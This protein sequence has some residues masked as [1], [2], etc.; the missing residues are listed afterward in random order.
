M[1]TPTIFDA[2]EI[3]PQQIARERLLKGLAIALVVLVVIGVPLGY[4]YRN[5]FYERAVDAFFQKV[6]QKDFETAFALWTADPTWKQHSEK[7]GNYTYGQF[8]LDW[9]PSG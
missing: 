6:E 7:Y 5:L 1:S 9:G 3:T 2:K 4:V 8:Q